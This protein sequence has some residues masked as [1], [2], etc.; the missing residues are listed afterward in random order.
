MVWP[1]QWNIVVGILIPLEMGCGQLGYEIYYQFTRQGGCFQPICVD[2]LSCTWTECARSSYS[3][4]LFGHQF[5]VVNHGLSEHGIKHRPEAWPKCAKEPDFPIWDNGLWD[6]KVYPYSFKEY[7]SNVFS[8]D[9]LL[10]GFQNGHLIE[11]ID[12]NDNTIISKPSRRKA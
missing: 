2:A 3:Q 11:S 1:H 8:C 5:G 4:P 7:L 10:V 12:D 6:P 9:T